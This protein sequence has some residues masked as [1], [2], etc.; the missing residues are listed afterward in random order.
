[1]SLSK[2]PTASW[3]TREFVFP[4]QHVEPIVPPVELMAIEEPPMETFAPAA[5]TEPEVSNVR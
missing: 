2:E 4:P 5:V 1:M 3:K